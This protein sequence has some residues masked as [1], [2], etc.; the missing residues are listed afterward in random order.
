MGLRTARV[1]LA[2][3][4]IAPVLVPALSARAPA[5]AAASP[6]TLTPTPDDSS[7]AYQVDSFHD[8]H[9][10]GGTEKPPLTK[11]WTRDLGG[12]VSY[13]LVVDGMI[14]VTAPAQGGGQGATLY[15]LD[16]TTGKDVWGPI[17]VGGYYPWSA[18]TYGEGRVY[19]LNSDGILEARD[20][21]T[22]AQAWIV[23][24]P[25]Q[26]QFSSAP[27]YRNGMVYV[28]GAGFGGT[29]Y[30]VA[31][32]DGT[33]V[34]TAPVMNGMD[35]SPA[36]S[37]TG[38][39]VSY[40]CLQTYDFDPSTGAQI[41]H[42]D[43]GCEGGGGRTPVLADSRVWAR[44]GGSGSLA[45]SAAT[46]DVTDSFSAY[47]APAFDGHTGFFVNGT[48][49]QARDTLTDGPLWSFSGDG[50]LSTA[51]LVVNG[52]V[53]MGSTS[54]QLWALDEAT[55]APVWSDNVG[56]P[57]L[58]PDEYTG[59]NLPGF[60]VGQGL[61]VVPASTTLVVYASA[62]QDRGI[63]LRYHPVVP[64]RI[65]DTR[66]GVGAPTAPLGAGATLGLQ[67]TGQGGVP[68]TGVSAV[69]LNVTAVTPTAQSWLVA[70][71]VGE[72]RP[73]AANLNF[74]AGQIVPN[75]VVAK[76]GAGGKVNLYNLA[77]SVDVVADVSGWYGDV[78]SGAHYN[79]V[80]PA[81][82]LDTRDGTGAPK[83]RLGADSTLALQVTG[84]GGVP[85]TGVSAVVM[86]VT[87]VS[88]SAQSWL[89]AWPD[90]TPKPL[91]A[92]LNYLPNQ[93]VP[94]LVEVKVGDGGKVDL[95][96]RFGSTDVVA[97]VAGWYGDAGGATGDGYVAVTPA[98]ILDT[99]YGVGASPAP[100][101]PSS[102]LPL[103]VTGRG[104]VPATGVSAVVLNVTVVSPT[105]QSWLVAWPAG[106]A[107]PL[108]ANLNYLPGQIVPNLVVAKVGDGGKVDLFNLFGSTDVVADVA[109]WYG[110]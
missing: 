76:V 20:A 2:V 86:N 97:D 46:G 91:A 5:V 47:P 104:G 64:S 14:Y 13:P 69:V 109:G 78:T 61:V 77:G 43:P 90:G 92:N 32:A 12:R 102:T 26:Y 40:A 72:P 44:D 103:Q 83:A 36:V 95:Y 54:G 31:A 79:P 65:L 96:N 48:V 60:G 62:P 51:P 88:P 35:S 33:V 94:N 28:G 15:A 18:L 19:A 53:Y 10:A 110:T 58:S 24:L 45:F 49:L 68:A 73:L 84:E 100:L 17:D 66:V 22:G 27:T 63:P 38:V 25:G 57:I 89:V 75:L 101:G 87:V 55:G 30:G 34:W 93:V 4:F 39:Y 23:D 81:R 16:A 1:A 99:R 82:I 70:W 50:Q 41:W 6:L 37:D 71:P 8:G 107:R 80:T 105:A 7:V 85:A 108:A 52:Y 59:N 106:E 98:R 9:L 11:Q 67:V 56:A 29:V 74:L 42:H 3:A 21:R